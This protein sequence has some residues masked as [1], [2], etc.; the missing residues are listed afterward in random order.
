MTA[1]RIRERI[2]R[3]AYVPRQRLIELDMM[4]QLDVGRAAL[5]E[6]LRLLASEGLVEIELY[7]GAM[8]RAMTRRDAFE[9][10]LVREWLESLAVREAAAACASE[11]TR[12]RVVACR[13][14]M[15][16]AAGAQ[17]SHQA[18]AELNLE[19]HRLI[20]DL[21]GNA[22]L[23]R[24]AEQVQLPVV[25]L[26]YSHLLNKPE[27]QSNSLREHLDIIETMLSEDADAAEAAMRRHVRRSA[28]ALLSL[29]DEYYA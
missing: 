24:V 14:S 27:A 9:I 7:R 26:I 28:E 18:Y 21:A 13:A 5:R 2:L 25:R 4:R 12:A 3:G 6:A 11:A 19:F 8:V 15:M 16:A 1:A 22:T 10:M 23:T 17:G 29:P 20:A